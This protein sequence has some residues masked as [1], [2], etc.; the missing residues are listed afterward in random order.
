MR[1]LSE[2]RRERTIQLRMPVTVNIDPD[3]RRAV[4]ILPALGV[5]EIGPFALLDDQR[6]FLFPL[7]HLRERMPEI[8]MVPGREWKTLGCVLHD[9]WESVDLYR[10]HP[11]RGEGQ[12]RA[13]RG[14]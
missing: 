8:G 10:A 5:D 14:L 3:G 1:D 13:T 7:L 9:G 12:Q 2:L 6:C 4:E 11:R